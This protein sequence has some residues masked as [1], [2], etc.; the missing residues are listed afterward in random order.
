MRGLLVTPWFAAGVG[1][2][3]AAALALATPR[4][5]VLS[6]GP[7]DPGI[8]CKLPRCAS[9]APRHGPGSLATAKPGVPLQQ[10]LIR[11]TTAVPTVVAARPSA[12]PRPASP[13]EI[14]VHYAVI[15][16]SRGTF[17]AVITVQSSRKLGSWT[18]GFVIPGARISDVWGGK[19]QPS[20]S[21]SGG[22]ASGQPWPWAR[23]GPGTARIVIFATGRPRVPVGCMFDG[24]G[25]VFS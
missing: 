3:I 5:A 14:A 13:A 17:L 11:R 23:S 25:C 24:E 20:A 9:P 21:G 6:Y 18:L 22:V 4:H 15:R 16:H 1:I 7:V 12:T 10:P 2:L 8:P 19:W